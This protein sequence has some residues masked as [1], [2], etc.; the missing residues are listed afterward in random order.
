MKNLAIKGI[1]VALGSNCEGN[2]ILEHKHPDWNIDRIAA[3]TG[4]EQRFLAEAGETGFDLATTATERLFRDY[5]LNP[6]DFD[7]VIFCTQSPDYRIPGNASLLHG[8]FALR[9]DVAAFDINLA[10]SGF[11]YGLAIAR[12]LFASGMANN[13]LFATADTYSKF[14]DEE[15]RATRVL[16]GDG[17]T[18]TWLGASESSSGILD[19]SLGSDGSG[20]EAFYVPSGACR[21]LQGDANESKIQMSG[22]DILKFTYSTIPEHIDEFLKKNSVSYDDIDLFIFHQASALVL[23][24][25]TTKL[26]LEEQKVYRNL[27]DKGN[28]VSSSIPCAMAQAEAEG[29][30]RQGQTV[31]VCGFGAGLSWGSALLKY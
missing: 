29:K 25:L 12:G 30:L 7:A 26:D 27:K 31:L 2:E 9:S 28:L 6:V 24:S 23:D 4:I 13:I 14:I 11:P 20:Y 15:D 5:E 8:K 16:F 10:C 18:A 22:R 21:E 3:R 19:V 1:S 17:A